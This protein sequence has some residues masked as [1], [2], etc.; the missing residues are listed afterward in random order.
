MDVEKLVSQNPANVLWINGFILCSFL[1]V[2]KSSWDKC[3]LTSQRTVTFWLLQNCCFSGFQRIKIILLT[4][5]IMQPPRLPIH[6]WPDFGSVLII[7]AFYG[8]DELG[9]HDCRFNELK[10]L[11][12]MIKPIKIQVQWE[13]CFPHSL[14]L[15]EKVCAVKE[16]K[17]RN[18]QSDQ[19]INWFSRLPSTKFFDSIREKCRK[20]N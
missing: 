19:W 10:Q 14:D 3:S 1:V 8:H 15:Q 4:V 5:G 7:D 11:S 6:T 16:T 9:V 18:N 2:K 13:A 20:P 12:D 17:V